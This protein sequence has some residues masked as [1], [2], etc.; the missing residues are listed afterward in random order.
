MGAPLQL[1]RDQVLAFR[2]QVQAL[3][4][5]LPPGGGSLQLAA[6]AGLQDSVPRSALH[7][8]HARVSGVNAETWEDPA[9]VQVWGPR[10]T[11]YVVPADA[12]AAFTLARMPDKGRMP[13]RAEG[14]AERAAR[15]LRGRRLP[16]DALAQS[17]GIG[18]DIRYAGLTGTILIRWAGARQPTV[19]NVSRPAITAD[20]ALQ[21]LI[22]RYLHVYG[23]STIWAFAR[24]AGID[25]LRAI[26]KFEAMAPKLLGVRTPLGEAWLLAQDE[27]AIRRRVKPA[28]S[29]RLLPSGD[30][31]YLLWAADREFLVA[32]AARRGALWTTRVWP[33]ALLLDGE[34][35]GTWR[36]AGA[37]VAVSP[38][39]RLAAADRQR[40]EAEAATLPL[41][42]VT[43]SA[44]VQWDDSAIS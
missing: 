26:A 34:I 33:G 14:I 23:P 22:R 1:T 2:R 27:A 24:W 40:V 37:V 10:Y 25:E 44:R 21:E 28:D 29:V 8:L 9:L 13:A 39:R 16:A 38:W 11:A 3:D 17:L 36:R 19:W 43:D 6:W 18:N 32:D 12:H 30:P 7:S 4:Q 31:Y 42:D 20:E 5:R 41:P 15:H 35:A